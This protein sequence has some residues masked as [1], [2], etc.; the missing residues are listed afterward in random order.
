[1]GY[2]HGEVEVLDKLTTLLGPLP[3]EWMASLGADTH[4]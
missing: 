3:E 4:H 1:M 2:V